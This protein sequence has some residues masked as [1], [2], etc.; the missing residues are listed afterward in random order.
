MADE[1]VKRFES[2]VLESPV[3][4]ERIDRML[5]DPKHADHGLQS[6][7]TLGDNTVFVWRVK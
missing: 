1:A 7:Y 6:I 5:N 2:E 3:L 4:K